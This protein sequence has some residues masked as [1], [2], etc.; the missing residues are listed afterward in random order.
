MSYGSQYTRLSN[1]FPGL[2]EKGQMSI[3]RVVTF[4]GGGDTG[5][6]TNPPLM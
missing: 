1:E 2:Y 6:R 5:K 3:T 4:R